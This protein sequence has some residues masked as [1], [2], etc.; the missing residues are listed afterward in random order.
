MAEKGELRLTSLN[1]FH[2]RL[3]VE[4][5]LSPPGN[6]SGQERKTYPLDVEAW[7][8]LAEDVDRN[9]RQGMYILLE[10]SLVSRTYIDKMKREQHRMVVKATEIAPLGTVQKQ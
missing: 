9:I 2:I 3:T 7:G 4:N 1:I 5:Y 8:D 10:G 6:M